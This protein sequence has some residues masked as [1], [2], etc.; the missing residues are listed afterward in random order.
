M[1]EFLESSTQSRLF[2]VVAYALDPPALILLTTTI[3]ELPR[4]MAI[5]RDVTREDYTIRSLRPDQIDRIADGNPHVFRRF[6]TDPLGLRGE[7]LS[8]V[9]LVVSLFG[10]PFFKQKAFGLV[11]ICGFSALDYAHQL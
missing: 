10:A 8:E 4:A 7:D 9:G 3:P 6:T 1:V 2:P 11:D 5:I